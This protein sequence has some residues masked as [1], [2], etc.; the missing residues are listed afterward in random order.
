MYS[1]KLLTRMAYQNDFDDFD[2]KRPRV[3]SI[4]QI[5]SSIGTGMPPLS[6]EVKTLLENATPREDTSRPEVLINV[7]QAVLQILAEKV[8]LLSCPLSKSFV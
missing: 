8:C 3:L 5:T 6:D 7:P 1:Y 2:N 4:G